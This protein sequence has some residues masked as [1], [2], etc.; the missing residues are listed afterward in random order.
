[1]S[2]DGES[3][4]RLHYSESGWYT[5]I[6]QV[7]LILFIVGCNQPDSVEGPFTT[8]IIYTDTTIVWSAE[9][10]TVKLNRS[11]V[12]DKS[13]KL[14]I[15]PGTHVHFVDNSMLHYGDMGM[16]YTSPPEVTIEGG[17]I[18]R[19]TAEHPVVITGGD[20]YEQGFYF[21]R[22]TSNYQPLEI[23][24]LLG[25]EQLRIIGASPSIKYSDLRSISL[26]DCD[27][28]YIERSRV[29]WFSAWN[30][31]GIISNNRIK[32]FLTLTG[33][34]QVDSN[35]IGDD[36]EQ[37]LY[38][39]RSQHDDVSVFQDNVIK[40]FRTSI[41]IFSGSPTINRNNIQDYIFPIEVVPFVGLPDS[42]TLD[43]SYNWWD[44]RYSAFLI[45]AIAYQSNGGTISEKVIDVLP[46]AT[47]PF[48]LD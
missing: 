35:I 23:S 9:K 18:C 47:T 33:M 12:I 40:N 26:E 28:V 30:S 41:Y 27:S 10:D 46:I 3:V 43:F 15:E 29:D 37:R 31:S 5:R 19:G 20:G 21:P 24:W 44:T 6:L 11:I 45:N 1:M 39:I 36:L 16:K 4:N 48:D 14:I 25:L 34:F 38:G 32:S 22:D 8:P 13:S 42:D 7:A 17:L 2:T